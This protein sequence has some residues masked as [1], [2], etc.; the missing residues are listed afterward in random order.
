MRGDGERGI[1]ARRA[2][3]IRAARWRVGRREMRD[4]EGRYRLP[5]ALRRAM[6]TAGAIDSSVAR[7]PSAA[8]RGRFM[9]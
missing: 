5:L 2:D 9:M 6:R 8:V 3:C 7:A 1:P 4:G